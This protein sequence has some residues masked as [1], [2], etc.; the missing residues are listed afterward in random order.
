M[1]FALCHC[2][3]RLVKLE[4]QKL[5]WC[6]RNN[7]RCEKHSSLTK[8]SPPHCHRWLY[9]L[10]PRPFFCLD[11]PLS[12]TGW[13]GWLVLPHV[14]G[15]RLIVVMIHSV[16]SIEIWKEKSRNELATWCYLILSTPLGKKKINQWTCSNF[17]LCSHR[18]QLLFLFN[19]IL[20]TYCVT[21]SVPVAKIRNTK[22][23][24]V[25]TTK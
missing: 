18:L 11:G 20:N 5:L 22:S 6:R 19:A 25:T 1:N 16:T 17:P 7:Q 24:T 23:K 12:T 15:N 10:L 3:L 2:A 8:V 4:A 14:R 21:P 13:I 9:H